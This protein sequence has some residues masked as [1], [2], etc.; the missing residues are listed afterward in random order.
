MNV[1]NVLDLLVLHSSSN[2]W[3]K[4]DPF[5]APYARILR[6]RKLEADRLEAELCKDAAS[7]KDFA[8][9]YLYYGLHRT[10]EGWILREWAPNATAMT[11]FGDMSGWRIESQYNFTRINAHGDWELSLPH[12]AIEHLQKYRLMINW[13]GGSGERIPVWTRRAVQ[14]YKTLSFN[15]EVW[16][17]SEP[18]KWRHTTDLL[19]HEVPF[20]YEAHV[21]MAQ[22]D[23]RVGTYTEFTKHILPRIKEAGYNTIQLMAIQEHPYYGSFGYQ[24]SSYFAPSSRFGTPDELK[25]LIDTAHGYG[26]AVIMDIVHS[27]AVKNIVEGIGCFDGTEYQFFHAGDRG[28]HFAWDSRCFDYAKYETIHFLLSNCRYWLEEFKFDGFRFDGVTSMLYHDHGLSRVF[29]GYDQYFDHNVDSDALSYLMLAT[30]ICKD[31]NPNSLLIAEEV[32][33]M[34]GLAVSNK[35]GGIGFDYRFAMGVPDHWIKLTKD[36]VDEEWHM[37]GLWH[38]LANRRCDERTISYAESHDQ[39]IVGDQSLISRLIG[40]EIYSHMQVSDI[41]LKVDRGIALHKMIRLITAAAAGNGYM[42]FMGNEFGHP[43][44]IDFPR[45]GNNWSYHFARRQWSLGDNPDLKYSNLLKFDHDM[46]H[47]LASQ[48][49]LK[50]QDTYLRQLHEDNKLIAFERGE[51]LFIFN[52]HANNSLVDYPVSSYHSVYVLAL[53]TDRKE[54][55]GY[56]RITKEQ[57]IVAFKNE[58]R[59]ACY[60]CMW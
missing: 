55:G 1:A 12:S 30:K 41:S 29:S 16:A 25:N 17:P 8:A 22:E 49:I 10:T 52:F 31:C 45:E 50:S 56:D 3:L 39:A 51:F 4:R 46:I 28:T 34:P 27:H 48:K 6:E 21:G 24:V 23:G 54:Y 15:A 32:S 5:L 40:Y 14:D 38:E 43:E 11:L 35:E 36:Q 26:I 58:V 33:G 53:D 42:N 44:W 59:W 13:H 9:G 37:G 19:T 47:L 2:V 57:R 7:L 60:R 18:Y 20:I